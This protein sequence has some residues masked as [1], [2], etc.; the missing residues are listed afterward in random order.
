MPFRQ[1]RH[2]VQTIGAPHDSRMIAQGVPSTAVR[3]TRSVPILEI[4]RVWLPLKHSLLQN[5]QAATP[6]APC[7]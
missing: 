4:R 6:H 1:T 5:L 2:H 7:L 3:Y